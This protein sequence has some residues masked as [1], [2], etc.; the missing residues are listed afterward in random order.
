VL[1]RDGSLHLTFAD[2]PQGGKFLGAER[3]EYVGWHAPICARFQVMTRPQLRRPV[4]RVQHP[5]ITY[6]QRIRVSA[7]ENLKPNP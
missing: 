6:D 4:P 7:M 1:S 5:I 2:L 3:G